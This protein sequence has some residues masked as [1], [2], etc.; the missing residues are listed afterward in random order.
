M[1]KRSWAAAL[2]VGS[3]SA[4][5]MLLFKRYH[6]RLNARRRALGR[7]KPDETVLLV[8]DIQ[9]R[10]RSAID[11]M[12]QVIATAS[13][14]LSCAKIAAVPVVVTE[15]YPK[16]LLHTVSELDVSNSKVFEKTLFSMCTEEV[17]V[18]LQ[19]LG[20]RSALICGVET[21]VCVQ[22]TCLDLISQGYEVHVVSDGV[23]SQRSQDRDTALERLRQSGAFVTTVESVL[24]ELTRSKDSSVF[25][26]VS[27]LAKSH[28]EAKA[29]L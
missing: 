24:F 18:H 17:V 15:Q 26:E 7:L 21:H 29:K 3:I 9:E 11:T 10:F 28:A 16:G 20:R 23:S 4:I 25:K 14:L 1:Y 5:A 27:A 8:C 12:P 13:T 2:S 6:A 19:R 22:Q